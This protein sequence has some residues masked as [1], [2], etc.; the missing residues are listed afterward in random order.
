MIH[1]ARQYILPVTIVKKLFS[2]RIIWKRIPKPDYVFE[3]PD[4]GSKAGPLRECGN[5][6]PGNRDN[7]ARF[8]KA[9]NTKNP[10]HVVIC[11]QGM[12]PVL[13]LAAISDDHQ[14]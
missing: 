3:I 6:M 10:V 7:A 11:M 4:S 9:R 14:T 1:V 8:L 2:G 5:R 12:D 13:T